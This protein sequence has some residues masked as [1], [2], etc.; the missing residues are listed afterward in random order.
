MM[1][2]HNGG[3][4]PLANRLRKLSFLQKYRLKVRGLASL[5]LVFRL[6]AFLV[7]SGLLI[8]CKLN[9]LTGKIRSAF[10]GTAVLTM[11]GADTVSAQSES[12]GQQRPPKSP[13][14]P[15]RKTA[16]ALTRR[17]AN[18]TTTIARRIQSSQNPRTPL[19]SPATSPRRSQNEQKQRP[20]EASAAYFNGSSW[21]RYGKPFEKRKIC[22]LSL[23]FRLARPTQNCAQL[24]L[25]AQQ[26]DGL[27]EVSL[28]T[29]FA[30]F[31]IRNIYV[32]CQT[33]TGGTTPS[34]LRIAGNA[35]KF[36]D[37]SWNHLYLRFTKSRVTLKPD[38]ANESSYT[39]VSHTTSCDE[40]KTSGWSFDSGLFV[41]SVIDL[42]SLP[43]HIRG[44]V[45]PRKISK[46][47]GRLLNFHGE[48]HDRSLI[49]NGEIIS[50]SDS[51]V[52]DNGFTNAAL[53]QNLAS[54]DLKKPIMEAPE[55][56]DTNTSQ[57]SVQ[58]FP[59][60]SAVSENHAKEVVDMISSVRHHMPERGV[61]LY[62]LGLTTERKNLTRLC[63]VALRE[64][65][66]F[67][68]GRSLLSNLV[69]YQWKPLIVNSALQEFGG[70]VWADSS[71]RFHQS[72]L[73][74]PQLRRGRGVVTFG[75]MGSR[76]RTASFTHDG[77]LRYFD[78]GGTKLANVVVAFGTI[79]IWLDRPLV[80]NVLM[81]Q[82]VA[83]ALDTACMAPKGSTPFECDFAITQSWKF[84]GCHR[85]DQ[86]ALSVLLFK[87][88][89]EEDGKSHWV[90]MKEGKNISIER[91]NPTSHYAVHR[92]A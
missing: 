8:E 67:V 47:S 70:V 62:D 33:Q 84:L 34:C 79:N 39:A 61:V 41:A 24:L 89:G 6:T 17:P 13:S 64:F 36:A 35:R 30:V 51:N 87:A 44:A 14:N 48:M 85:F 40:S 52:V 15:T 1:A 81:R 92:C 63:R 38:T 86:S 43:E 7:V 46:C 80:R 74:I 19:S 45:K 65:S 16:V 23:T 57:V 5:K 58:R 82:W 20:E 59:V 28:S 12:E 10:P 91:D 56:K 21:Y 26:L 73:E 50:I 88:F 9:W 31:V 69:T 37:G 76:H 90:D 11:V 42:N 25:F 32:L 71:V 2:A 60:V 66:F 72:I 27:F 53:E 4:I 49:I 83:C 75:L 18:Q 77:T 29:Y 55:I 78:V 3:I 68:Q 22:T 54:Y